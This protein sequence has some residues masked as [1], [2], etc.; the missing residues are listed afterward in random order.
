MSTS[1]QLL[2]DGNNKCHTKDMRIE[3]L[4]LIVLL[5]V[6]LFVGII[7]GMY[8]LTIERL[9]KKNLDL[10]LNMGMFKAKKTLLN[11]TE[12]HFYK[13]LS[14]F[15]KDKPYEV[16]VQVDLAA[17]IAVNDKAVNYYESLQDL[18]KSIDY[19]I[20]DKESMRTR[21]AIELNGPDH[22]RDSRK[23]RDKFLQRLF[24]ECGIPFLQVSVSDLQDEEKLLQLISDVLIR[25]DTIE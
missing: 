12:H 18:D 5:G 4:H 7:S 15:V 2:V 11:S 19:V 10:E 1:S 23:I 17:L 25:S 9:R 21:I 13:L 3:N 24:K 16:F 14:Q 20:V 6:V 8:I 22:D